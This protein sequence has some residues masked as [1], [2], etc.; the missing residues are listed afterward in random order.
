MK[1]LHL[2]SNDKFIAP[3]IEFIEKNFS[4]YEHFFYII[5]GV[6]YIEISKKKFIKTRMLKINNKLF[7]NLYTLWIYIALYPR[8]FKSQKIILHSLF[9]RL[10]IIFLFLNPWF[11]K[12]C[13]W[14]MWG[15]YL[16]SYRNRKYN[17][18]SKKVYYK[19]EDYVKKNVG[20]ISY[21]AK[22]DYELSK[23]YYKSKGIPLRGIYINPVNLEELEKLEKNIKN[24]E[25]L[26]IQ[27]GNSA[28]SENNHFEIIDKLKKY[29]NEDIK[30]YAP[31]SYGNKEYALEIK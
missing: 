24:K 28:D 10:T 31:L 18:L 5:G 30:I 6:E 20:Y 16:Y 23:K 19:I 4:V 7:Q 29:K 12:K 25:T 15:G 26:N 21:L 14:V 27:I 22:G 2:M 3:Y 17:T 9:N 11:L 13:N 8:A 1:Y